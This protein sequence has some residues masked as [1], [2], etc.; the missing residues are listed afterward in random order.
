MAVGGIPRS[1]KPEELLQ[2]FGIS[3]D[4]IVK[5]VQSVG[6]DKGRSL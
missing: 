2:A 5:K 1:G 6:H 4:A 3:A